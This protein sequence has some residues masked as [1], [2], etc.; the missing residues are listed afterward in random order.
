MAA[1]FETFSAL[2]ENSLGSI[3]FHRISL[4][5]KALGEH[6]GH[7]HQAH[8]VFDSSPHD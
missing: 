7:R 2:T 6:T 5:A 3:E 4:T 1:A 8:R